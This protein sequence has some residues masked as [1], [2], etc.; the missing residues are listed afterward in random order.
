M[1]RYGQWLSAEKNWIGGYCNK[2]K[3]MSILKVI[4][5]TVIILA[6][7][8]GGLAAAGSGM[9]AGSIIEGALGGLFIG[10]FV[11]V[12]YIAILFPLLSPKRYIKSID[13]TVSKMGL[14]GFSKELLA[15]EFLEAENNLEKTFYFDMKGPGSKNTPA[16]FVVS[17]HFAMLE[18]GSP[19]AIIVKLQDI[20]DIIPSQEKK[21]A[22]RRSG[23]IATTYFFTLY[24]I[25]FYRYDR[26][27]KGLSEK[28]LPDEAMGFMDKEIRDRAMS[29]LEK[30][31]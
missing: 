27:Q 3:L 22:I 25:Q 29:L 5:A 15:K 6:L 11:C 2:V 21:S 18:G 19:Y 16:R 13:R 23:N 7:L 26:A 4:P 9:S 1:D 20:K 12:I 30:Y 17:E 10:V 24:T 31:K 28:D 8:F 14:D